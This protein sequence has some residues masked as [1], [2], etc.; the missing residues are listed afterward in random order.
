MKL[1]AKIPEGPLEN[2]WAQYKAQAKLVNP[3]NRKKLDVIVIGTGLAGL[4]S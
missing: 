3:A 4:N 2:K 1:D